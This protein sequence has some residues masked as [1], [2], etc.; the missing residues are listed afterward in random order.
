[1]IG[2]P[3]ALAL[4]SES[5][6]A[7]A[8]GTETARPLTFCET[9]ASISCA[10]FCGSL[11][12]GLQVSLTPSAL[13]AASAPFLTTDQKEPSSECV[14]IAMVMPLPCV[15]LTVPDADEPP[16]VELPFSS[17]LLLPHPAATSAATTRPA[18]KTLASSRFIETPSLSSE[19]VWTGTRCS[20]AHRGQ[21]HRRPGA[22]SR[23]SR[24]PARAGAG[25]RTRSARGGRRLRRSS[26][27]LRR[28]AGTA[29]PA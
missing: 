8:F 19:P 22:P 2:M 26:H 9:A 21:D 14:T 27:P 3:A 12:D 29:R 1:M 17:L 15:W 28:G 10:C 20:C 16:E 25:A 24:C 18:K 4:A 7:L 13:A 23:C 5:L 6:I 11:F